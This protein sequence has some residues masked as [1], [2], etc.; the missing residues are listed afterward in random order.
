VLLTGIQCALR[1]FS[2]MVPEL[3]KVVS[4]SLQPYAAWVGV[5]DMSCAGQ[6]MHS[7][8]ISSDVCNDACANQYN[9]V[10]YSF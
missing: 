4:P 2:R 10:I 7:L 9:F 3:K 6:G 1:M 5:T 8:F